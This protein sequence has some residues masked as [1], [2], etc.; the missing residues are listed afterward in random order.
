VTL[1]AILDRLTRELL[2]RLSRGDSSLSLAEAERIARALVARYGI[3]QAVRSD[4]DPATLA[5]AQILAR[6]LSSPGEQRLFDTIA[7]RTDADLAR[8]AGE[9]DLRI[10]KALRR[11]WS[12]DGFDETR[13]RATLRSAVRGSR[14]NA[15]T[16]ARTAAGAYDRAARLIDAESTADGE[17][18]YRYAGPP[19]DRSFCEQRLKE[20]KDGKTYT[21]TEIRKLSNGQGL[22]A[23]LYCG[24]YNCRHQWLPEF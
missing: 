2:Q 24:G 3:E 10:V 14:A 17:Q 20:A 19:A 11:T 4:L 18:R 6:R 22:P 13:L 15:E 23:E 21:L 9:V 1:R 7:S 5:E 16:L 8:V 12:E